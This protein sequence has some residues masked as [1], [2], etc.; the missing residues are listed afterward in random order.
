MNTHQTAQ[1]WNE[2]AEAWTTLA[3][4]GYDIY[5]DHLN[6]PAF[7]DILPDV[8]RLSGLDIGCG[9]GYN[10]RLLAKRAAKIK[11]IDISDRFIEKAK[12]A[13]LQNPAGI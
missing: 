7:F 9:E 4:A 13:E 3:R 5:R 8:N 10:T 2:N 6:T 12:E 11:A 1:Y